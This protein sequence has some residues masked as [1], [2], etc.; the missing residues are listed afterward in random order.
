MSLQ[1][2]SPTLQSY[3]VLLY[4]RALHPELFPLKGRRVVRHGAYEFEV[5]VMEGM[6]LLRFEYG[7]LCACELLTDQEGK[8]PETG[9]VSGFLAAGERDFEHKFVKEKVT[10]MTTVQTETLSENLYLA[11][12]EEMLD[13]GRTSEGLMHKWADGVGDCLSMIVLERSSREIRAESYHLIAHG[14]LVIRT[15][16]IFEHAQVVGA[17]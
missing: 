4:N 11:T 15:Q 16:T 1:V 2:K 13:F 17:V 12:M 6:H 8:L 14:G 3:Q 5:W 7:T 10:Y 9:V